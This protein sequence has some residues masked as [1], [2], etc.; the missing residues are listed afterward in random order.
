MGLT[1]I[2]L[3]MNTRF[4]AILM[5]TLAPWVGWRRT[6]PREK[7]ILIYE[8]TH[9]ENLPALLD[10]SEAHFSRVTV[11][12]KDLSYRHLSAEGS[13]TGRWPKTDFF[14]Q[15]SDTS[16]RRFIGQLFSFLKQKRYSHLHLATL[17]NN[18][19]LFAIRIACA[20]RVHISLTL[21][22]LNEYFAYSFHTLRDYSES[23]AKALLHR[24]IRNYAFFLPATVDLFRQKFPDAIAVFIPSRFYEPGSSL[25][26]RP[27]KVPGAP[28][29]IVIPGAV[30]PNRRDY[31]LV[32]DYLIRYFPGTIGP[33]QKL[34]LVLLGESNTAYGSG[35]VGEL[36]KLESGRFRLQAYKGY[37][38]ETEY[39]QRLAEAD[40]IW[41]PLKPN[42]LSMRGHPEIYGL[43]TA[44]GLTADLLLNNTPAL[45]PA[46]FAIPEPF[47][48]ALFIYHSGKEWQE[49]V[50]LLISDR[51]YAAKLRRNIHASFG[52]ITRQRFADSF[53]RLTGLDGKS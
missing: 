50:D 18:L 49:F 30:D 48:E 11:F 47:R 4:C 9:H 35:I 26:Q 40:L 25:M 6:Q 52:A 16:N 20:G 44:S 12:L 19:L 1:P 43:T 3:L 8:T 51:A 45:V 23:L 42:K 31:A 24:Q 27:E 28:F 13:P 21:H 7:K 41:S 38:P 32:I 33:S 46:S 5:S 29:T 22:E 2:P 37:I 14:V 53:L 17:D 36:R 15:A 39:E 34:Q 10:L